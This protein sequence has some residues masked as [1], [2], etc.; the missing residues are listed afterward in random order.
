MCQN[1]S[2]QTKNRKSVPAGFEEPAGV[3]LVQFRGRNVGQLLSS[4]NGKM[5][6]SPAGTVAF[7]V[8][9]D[10]KDYNPLHALLSDFS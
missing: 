1:R 2:K 8:H 10:F 5:T 9:K 3:H 4:R 6:Q 7:V